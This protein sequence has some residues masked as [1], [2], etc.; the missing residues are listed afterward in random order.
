[1][2]PILR[3]APRLAR[4]R[5]RR[6]VRWMSVALLALVA[7]LTTRSMLDDAARQRARWGRFTTVAVATRDLAPGAIVG[8]NDIAFVERPDALVADDPAIEPVGRSVTAPIARDEIVLA[9]RLSGGGSGP[10]A[11]LDPGAVA[12]AVPV[13]P[14]TPPVRAGDRV[15]V[16]AAVESGSRSTVGATRVAHRATVVS[17][18]ERTVLV[19]VDGAMA[20][21]VARALLDAAVVL[22]LTG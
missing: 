17:V 9:R 16:F 5:H 2:R 4:A 22:A 1:M 10:V 14:S 11:L 13:D 20:T 6:T 21:V 12:F 19:G 7:S 15:D 8:A 18:N 3:Q